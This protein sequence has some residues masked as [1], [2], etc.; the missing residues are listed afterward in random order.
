MGD[1]TW[2][3]P[4]MQEQKNRP[5]SVGP[6]IL[7]PPATAQGKAVLPSQSLGSTALARSRSNY[8]QPTHRVDRADEPDELMSMPPVANY[9]RPRDSAFDIV[10]APPPATYYAAPSNSRGLAV[11]RTREQLTSFGS[12]HGGDP[13]A[14][15]GLMEGERE[16]IYG[17]GQAGRGAG[18][19]MAG[20]NQRVVA[21]GNGSV[22]LGNQWPQGYNPSMGYSQGYGGPYGYN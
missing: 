8:T 6:M 4:D 13:F 16:S 20:S 18:F 22:G 15:S 1:D 10:P 3:V 12:D 11:P 9:E 19:N 7:P 5:P 17:P 14:G 21:G 2:D